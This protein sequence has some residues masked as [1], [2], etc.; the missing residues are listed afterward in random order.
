[1]SNLSFV[2]II[3]PCRNEDKFIGMC[4][5]SILV[6]DYP[7]ELVEILVVDGMSEDGTRRIVQRYTQQYPFVRLLNNPKKI[8][9][10]AFN[11]GVKKSIGDVIMIMGAHNT[12]STDYITKSVKYLREYKAD[13]VGG[14]MRTFSQTGSILGRAIVACLS[15]RFGVG[16]SYFRIHTDKPKSVDTVFGGCYEKNIF[17]K[18]GLFDE[19]L[20]RHQDYEFNSRIK[21]LGG[22]IYIFPDIV[23]VYYCRSALRALAK[24]LFA[25]GKW[26]VYAG[27]VKP[28][29]LSVRHSI[30]FA[31]VSSLLSGLILWVFHPVG[32]W[33][34]GLIVGSYALCSI[35]ASIMIS[36]RNGWKYLPVLPLVFVV[37]HLSYGIGSIWGLLTVRHWRKNKGRPENIHK[38]WKRDSSVEHI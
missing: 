20:E 8:T 13:N 10:V 23:S 14:I 35:A 34:L 1:L 17:Y 21:R 9:P 26:K 19:R 16:N 22:K 24:Q 11:V 37:Q 32:G 38:E 5:D 29:S 33:L 7:K 31:F 2:S 30:P 25:N 27:L 18:V 6:N 28:A 3:I 12:Y 15:H 36:A 4:L